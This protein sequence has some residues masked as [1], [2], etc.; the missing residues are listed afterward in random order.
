[1]QLCYRGMPW[2]RLD[3][4]WGAFIAEWDATGITRLLF[5][6]APE[7]EGTAAR[8]PRGL[9]SQFAAYLAGELRTFALSLAP[10][11][12]PFQLKVWQSLCGVPYGQ[13]TTYGEIARSIGHPTAAR[14]VGGAVGRNPLPILIPC[15]RVLPSSGKLGKFGP[16][17]V[18]KAR[19][20]EIEGARPHP[21]SHSR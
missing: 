5:P 7:P 4:R 19:L 11:G 9:A 8:P 6:G 3:T 17:P 21:E 16:G 1:M 2:T 20:L 15:H 12:T 14:A 18:W 13:T 10:H